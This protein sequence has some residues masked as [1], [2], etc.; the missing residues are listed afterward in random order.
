MELFFECAPKNIFLAPPGY[1]WSGLDY[2]G[3]ELMISAVVSGDTTML[4]AFRQPELKPHPE[5]GELCPNPYADLH[6]ITTRSAVFPK[7]FEGHEWYDWVKI[8]KTYKVPNFTEAPRQYGKKTN[9][10]AIYLCNAPTLAINLGIPEQL[11]GNI[12]QGHRKTYAGYYHWAEQQGAIGEA[13]GWISTPWLKRV[14]GVHEANAKGGGSAKLLAPNVCIQGTGADIAKAAMC[15]IFRWKEKLNKP[16]EFAKRPRLI[17]QVHDELVPLIPGKCTLNL[18][19]SKLEERDNMTVVTKACWDVP[20]ASYELALQI[21]QIMIDVETEA[22][23]GVLE[24]RV[25]M[26]NPAP[27]WSK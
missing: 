2:S 8:A 22:F 21:R 11:A 12:L 3:Q 13:C 14:R 15:R 17:G 16:I 1:F 7:I 18:D 5:T 9:F 6:T 25:D 24:G 4:E 19:K 20:E 26:P 10:S 23:D 27:W